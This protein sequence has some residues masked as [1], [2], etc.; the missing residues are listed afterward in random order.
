M[1][2]D[3]KFEIRPMTTKEIAATYQ[4]NLCTFR[5]WLSPFKN[6]IGEKVG[7]YYKPAQVKTILEVLGD[8]N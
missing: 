7:M 3:Y 4:V 6:K 1:K 2:T 5:K 8:P